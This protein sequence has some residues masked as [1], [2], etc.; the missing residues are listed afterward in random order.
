M[1]RMKLNGERESFS[2]NHFEMLNLESMWL[3]QQRG[4]G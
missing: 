3:L 2:E 4:G 1:K